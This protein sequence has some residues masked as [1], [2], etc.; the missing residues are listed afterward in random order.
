MYISKTY[1]YVSILL[2]IQIEEYTL[3]C[4]HLLM[5]GFYHMCLST[6]LNPQYLHVSGSSGLTLFNCMNS[7]GSPPPPSHTAI[8]P[9]T[10]IG[11]TRETYSMGVGLPVIG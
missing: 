11:G 3:H 4:E 9:S 6:H 7:L 5:R 10:S 2:V 8:N 1:V